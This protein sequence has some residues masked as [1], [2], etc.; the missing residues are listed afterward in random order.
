M[1]PLTEDKH[2]L[3]KN[4]ILHVRFGSAGTHT[5]STPQN[6]QV[7]EFHIPEKEPPYTTVMGQDSA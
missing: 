6:I 7:Q 2:A 4:D 5:V 3:V 1:M